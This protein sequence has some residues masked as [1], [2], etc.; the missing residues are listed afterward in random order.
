MA[1][2]C[3]RAFINVYKIIYCT[4]KKYRNSEE[5]VQWARAVIWGSWTLILFVL[6]CF[7]VQGSGVEVRWLLPSASLRLTYMGRIWYLVSPPIRVNY[8]KSWKRVM[9]V[10]GHRI[11]LPWTRPEDTYLV[12]I[13][14]RKERLESLLSET[15]SPN[16][17]RLITAELLSRRCDIHQDKQ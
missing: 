17:L 7:K 8:E 9:D 14:P 12:K 3:K 5:W 1:S 11:L 16:N 2:L 10:V 15:T 13:S 4:F 6:L